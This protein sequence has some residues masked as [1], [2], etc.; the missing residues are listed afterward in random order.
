MNW[1]NCLF[2][3]LLSFSLFFQ[4]PCTLGVFVCLFFCP[5]HGHL[6]VSICACF[7]ISP[8]CH[9]PPTF[10]LCFSYSISSS[11]SF[12]CPP[13]LTYFTLLFLAS[14]LLCPFP[15]F[16]PPPYSVRDKFVEVDLRPVCKHCYERLPDNMKRRL[17][18]RERDSKEK[19]KKSLIPMCLWSSL[20]PFSSLPL[21]LLWSVF[22]SF[23]SCVSSF[24]II[25]YISVLLNQH[26]QPNDESIYIYIYS[27][28]KLNIFK[29]LNTGSRP[30]L[31]SLKLQAGLRLLQ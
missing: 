24:L 1:P 5:A 6:P 31:L 20:S 3:L 28:H 2:A 10:P 29:W 8:S 23:T 12:S 16:S 26:S 27:M 9:H 15:P 7:C 25:P 13:S 4:L 19:K 30:K 22:I 21:F 18:K 17:A 11:P 14:L